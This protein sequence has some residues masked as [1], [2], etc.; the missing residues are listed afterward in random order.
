MKRR[1][2]LPHMI[3]RHFVTPQAVAG[4]LFPLIFITL[5]VSSPTANPR[6][7]RGISIAAV[8]YLWGAVLYAANRV[9]VH[10]QVGVWAVVIMFAALLTTYALVYTS[11]IYE[12]RKAFQ[13]D[14]HLLLE[15]EQERTAWGTYF[16]MLFFSVVTTSTVGYGS[17]VPYSR[18]A[19]A[20]V[21]SQII[22]SL[23]LV[24]VLLSNMKIITKPG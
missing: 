11:L 23:I 19:R 4:L 15:A 9:L 6:A 24:S 12:D 5:I 7:F 17:V 1:A 20:A 3:P 16:D 2:R 21:V 10:S 8:V 14:L 13:G 22:L 18:P